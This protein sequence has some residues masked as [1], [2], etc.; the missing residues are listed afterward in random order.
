MQDVQ[1]FVGLS[2]VSVR[3]FR[4]VSPLRLQLKHPGVVRVVYPLEETATQVC[5]V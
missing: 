4:R 2:V 5:C 1:P 3:P